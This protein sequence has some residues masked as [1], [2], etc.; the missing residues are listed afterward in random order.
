MGSLVDLMVRLEDERDPDIGIVDHIDDN[1]W[2]IGGQDI[3]PSKLNCCKAGRI[4]C[5]MVLPCGRQQ[6]LF[7]C[8]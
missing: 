6:N 2:I 1:R 8:H 7:F 3:F 4:F 5:S